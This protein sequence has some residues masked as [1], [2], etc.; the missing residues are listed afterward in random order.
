MA[1]MNWIQQSGY[2][3]NNKLN[4]D[5]QKAAQP[6]AR[7]RQFV[8][9][10]EAFGKQQGQTVNWLK[11]SNVDTRGGTVVETSTMPE[12]SQTLT[13]G[14]LTVNEMGLSLPFTFKLESLSEFDVKQIIREG[15]LDDAVKV[16]DGLVERQM[17][18][19]PLRYV[20]VTTASGSVT[21]NSTAAATNTSVLNSFHVRKMRLE[22]EKRNVPTWD[23]GD[24]VMIASLEAAE[25]LEG[26]L[27]TTNSYVE[28]G[29]AKILSGEIGRIHGVRV[30]KDGYASRYTTDATARTA[31]AITW[32]TGN[33][34]PGYMFGRPTVREAVVVPE[35]I[36]MKVVTDYGR[37][38]GIAW[39]GLMGHAIEWETEANARIIKWDSAA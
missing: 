29:Y 8:N 33:S 18:L 16:I 27:E 23:G 17:N 1:D 30:V 10:K 7:F 12:T 32:T 13:W 39:Y 35:E 14:T 31:T 11:V 5:F 28:S 3:T 9:F 15:L 2:L 21:T 25:S 24:Y 6:I 38:K 36:R 26:A 37:S 4:L 20:G 34:G 22:L 19:T